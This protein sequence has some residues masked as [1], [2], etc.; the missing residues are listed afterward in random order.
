MSKT[1]IDECIHELIVKQVAM[2][3]VARAQQAE[4][5]EANITNCI[6]ER[7]IES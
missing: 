2:F 3:D 7:E 5:N 1:D 4:V 6:T